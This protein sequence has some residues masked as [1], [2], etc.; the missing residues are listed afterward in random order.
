MGMNY[1]GTRQKVQPPMATLAAIRKAQGLKQAVVCERVS[2]I[3]DQALSEGSLS[4][5]E[6]GWRGVSA[7]TLR[8]LETA[9]GL[10]HQT[11][12]VDYEPS[13]DRR[14]RADEVPA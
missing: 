3:T 4:A 6:N 1:D 7:V 14:K 13:H 9:L 2:A 12:I 5:I 10:P 11:L 8:A